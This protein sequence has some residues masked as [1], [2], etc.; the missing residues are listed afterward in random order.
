MD[1]APGMSDLVSI[2]KC[3]WCRG[4]VALFRPKT[5]GVCGECVVSLT[6]AGLSHTEIY[7]GASRNKADTLAVTA[8]A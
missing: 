7:R 2:G 5:E 8:A 1:N 3:S 4:P 6:H